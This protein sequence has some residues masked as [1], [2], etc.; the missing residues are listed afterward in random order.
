MT[1]QIFQA[2]TIAGKFSIAVRKHKAALPGD[3][4]ND[5]LT[6]L[7]ETFGRGGRLSM[8]AQNARKLTEDFTEAKGCRG[9][10]Y[11][12]RTRRD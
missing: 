3:T 11:I 8:D 1:F 12:A 5:A 9:W 10:G 6:I 2:D 4:R 7:I